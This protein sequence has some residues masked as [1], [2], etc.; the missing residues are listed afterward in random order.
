MGRFTLPRDLYHGKDAL[1]A[2][3]TLN[4]KK[5]VVVVG[6]GRAPNFDAHAEMASSCASLG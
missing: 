5:A 1:E 3:K 4:G 6:G 2:L